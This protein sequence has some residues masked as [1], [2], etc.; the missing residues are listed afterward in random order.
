MGSMYFDISGT[1]KGLNKT[2]GDTIE[3]KFVPKSLFKERTISGSVKDKSGKTHF[4]FSGS[5][6]SEI[7]I[8]DARGNKSVFWKLQE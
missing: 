1:V 4:T 2:T 8:E 3:L 7:I 5:W 6:L